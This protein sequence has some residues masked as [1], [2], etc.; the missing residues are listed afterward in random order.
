MITRDRWY[1][2][3]RLGGLR[4][5]AVAIT[6]LN[7]LGHFVFG[8][9][10]SYAQ[11]LCALA[12]AYSMELLL[13]TVDALCNHRRPRFLGGLRPLTDF[14]LSAHITGLAVA[15]LLYSNERLWPT[16]F[17]AAA[18]VGSKHVFRV[19][20]GNDSRHVFNPSNFGIAL[21]LLLFPW[22]GIAPPYHFSENLPAIGRW[23]LPAVIIV[24]GTFLNV[25]FTR[26]I[27]LIVAWVGGFG[28]QALIRSL[29]FDTPVTAALL[30]MTGVAF[31]LFSF[32]MVTDPA[33]TPSKSRNQVV[34]GLGVSAVY[35][36]LMLFHVVFG[37]FFSL[38]IVCGFRFALVSA[39]TK[40][41][42]RVPIP[43]QTAITARTERSPVRA[44]TSVVLEKVDL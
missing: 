15:M 34:F 43:A 29:I 40:Y 7:L 21:T 6:I 35:C 30:P 1:E 36:L 13:E 26:R 28:F 42:A 44:T 19:K 18:A 5:F 3:D 17:A 9:E 31:I 14:L 41:R 24:S 39:L 27:P 2:Q 8:F 38:A 22:V 25:R 33:T 20:A 32:Y 11:P 37:L 16:A 23:V 12:T 4:R 10:Q